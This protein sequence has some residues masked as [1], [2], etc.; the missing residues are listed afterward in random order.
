MYRAFFPLVRFTWFVGLE[1]GV[2]ELNPEL[3]EELARLRRQN[4]QLAA[5]VYIPAFGF[6]TDAD[7]GDNFTI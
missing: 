1:T 4:E 7:R 6:G 2:S 3:S 5:K